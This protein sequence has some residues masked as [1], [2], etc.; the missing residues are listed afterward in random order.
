MGHAE[1]QPGV[2]LEEE[3]MIT[4]DLLDEAFRAVVLVSAVLLASR[5]VPFVLEWLR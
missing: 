2:E 4:R 5:A 3:A 1:Q